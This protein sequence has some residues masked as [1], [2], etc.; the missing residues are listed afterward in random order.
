MSNLLL[1][2][3]AVLMHKCMNNLAPD[4]LTSLSKK[5]SSI[6][7]HNTKN[8]NNLDIPKCCTAKAQNSFSY[9]GVSIWNSLPSEILNSP[10]VSVF[11][12]KLK[13]Y[14]FE[15]WLHSLSLVF[16]SFILFYIH[17]IF[18]FILYCKLGMKIS[19]L[20]T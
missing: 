3:D 19:F 7:Q 6:H 16:I 17:V 5:R 20:V 12:R 13:S 15:R 11:K 2:R 8:S 9:R 18:V 14:D 4:Y 10:S 1:I